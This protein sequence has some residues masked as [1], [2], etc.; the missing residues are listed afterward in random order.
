MALFPKKCGAVED[1]ELHVYVFIYVAY[2]MKLVEKREN[3]I[4]RPPNVHF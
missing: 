4:H 1:I 2:T 3:S